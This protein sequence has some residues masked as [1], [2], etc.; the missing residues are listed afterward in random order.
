MGCFCFFVLVLR[1]RN[2][3]HERFCTVWMRGKLPP[4]LVRQWIFS[5]F[6]I[7]LKI[8][9]ASNTQRLKW[10]LGNSFNTLLV[11][12]EAWDL[13]QFA[14]RTVCDWM[15][16]RYRD[17]RSQGPACWVFDR[18]LMV[19]ESLGRDISENP[20]V[21]LSPLPPAPIHSPTPACVSTGTVNVMI[22]RTVR[23]VSAPEKW[24]TIQYG[25]SSNV[26]SREMDSSQ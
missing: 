17:C 21:S 19:H 7:W 9:R 6:W 20:Q 1:T 26:I 25:G 13:S 8:Y 12:T 16:P 23:L 3:I 24:R 2:I 22:H 10:Q 18:Q 11:H 5:V 4:L 15:S 14:E